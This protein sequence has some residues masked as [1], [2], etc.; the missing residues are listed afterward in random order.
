M[1]NA[2]RA[3]MC[4][5]AWLA[6]FILVVL[7]AALF[8]AR[9]QVPDLD[10]HAP[11]AADDP[12]T[13]AVMRD[14]AE[15]LLPVYQEADSDRYLANLS[16]LQIVAG[17]YAAADVSRQ[18]LRER[19]RSSDAGRPVG[20]AA[21]YDMYAYAKTIEVENR[22]AFAQA[23][24]RA[25]DEAIPR[26][27]DHDAYLVTRWLKAAPGVFREAFQDL[28]NQQRA[29][30]NIGQAEAVGLIWAYLAFSAYRSFA[31]LADALVAEDDSRRYAIR[32][33]VL[34]KT[35]RGTS[36]AVIVVRAQNPSK[37]L[38]T[39]LEFGV[40][41][42]P[43]SAKESAAHGYVGVVAY[44]RGG[45]TRLRYAIPYQN[46]GDDARA[47]INWIV[48]QPWS[49]GR[50]G[51]YGDG[52]G[53]FTS[54]AAASRLPDALKAIATSGAT[55]PGINFPMAGSIFQNSA[56]RWSLYRST[57]IESVE[58]SYYDDARWRALDQKW[59]LSGRRYRDLGRLNKQPNPIFIRWLNHPS[60][61]PYWQKAN[62]LPEQFARINIPVLTITGYF[63]ASEPGALYN[64]NQHYRYNTHADHTLLIGPYDDDAIQRNPSA[65]MQGYRVDSAALIDVHELQY[66][67]F[68]HVFKG[69]ASPSLLTDRI[70]YEVMGANEWRHAASLAAMT[71]DSLRFYLDSTPSREGRH[72]MR[73]KPA[74]VAFAAQTVNLADRTD[75]GWMPPAEL[76]TKDLASHNSIAFVSEPLT[77]PIDVGGLFSAR[78]AF[79]VNKMDMD[80]NIMLYERLPSGDYVCLFNPAYEFRA[81]YAQDRVIRHL[82]GAG[83]RQELSIKPER[84]TSRRLQAG[85]RLVMVLGVNKRPDREINYGT[86]NDV[87]E[88]SIADGKIPLKVRWYSDSYV[89]IPVAGPAP[90]R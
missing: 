54:W 70:N 9:A 72:L 26:L 36:I 17:D 49:D 34:L 51:M 56:Y 50:V 45:R 18:T 30:D 22:V 60:Y 24:T 74:K 10:F 11:P 41:D 69:S 90:R 84:M 73:R 66:Q 79:T 87:S 19:R 38:P 13:P 63:S 40:D 4:N 1:R 76:I 59:Y 31:P 39:L 20:R 7:N 71:G 12:S 47:V 75:A 6:G 3:G 2:S 88:E 32:N 37:A 62:P 48:K 46:E 55:A 23:F 29:K 44:T 61:D 5:H 83:E 58:K 85:S 21:I 81:S 52:Y 82:I 77:K 89:E 8:E 68:D 33:D 65:V 80:L 64:F 42:T 57:S 35:S 16:A 67:W 53:G 28:L 86:G 43:D 78:L 27:N 25:F 15:R 14:L